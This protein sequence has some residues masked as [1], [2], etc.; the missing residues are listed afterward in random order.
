[1]P[2]REAGWVQQ[3][4][5]IEADDVEK[6]EDGVEKG[7]VES[8]LSGNFPK[9]FWV[10][11]GALPELGDRLPSWTRAASAGACREFLLFPTVVCRLH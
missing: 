7:E 9:G 6:E 5:E 4:V 8:R 10:E 2:P 3:H 1:M 11:M